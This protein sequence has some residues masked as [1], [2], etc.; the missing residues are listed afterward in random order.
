MKNIAFFILPLLLL[1]GCNT[2]KNVV[3]F[4]PPTE[5]EYELRDLDT[6]VITAPPYSETEELE[7]EEDYGLSIYNP[8]HKRVNDLLHTKLDLKFDWEN[9]HVLGK[10]TLTFEPYF[11]PTQTL[12]LDA[13]DFDI[14][15]V[16]LE[17]SKAELKYEYDNEKLIIDLGKLYKKGE[18][19]S[20]FIDYTA[21]PAETG[22]SAAI[23]SDQGL[24][25]INPK[26]EDGDKPQQI[27]TQ[28]ETEWNSRW[29]PTIDKPNERCTQEMLLTVQ[30]RFTTLSNGTLISSTPNN[31]GTRT[32]YWKMDQPHAPYLFMVAVGEYAVVKEN[33]KDV[34]L[35]YYVEPEY[36]SSAKDIFS[37][38]PEMLD[39]F[40]EKLGLKYPWPKY[41]QIVVRDYVSGAMENTT[42]VIYGEFVQK[43]SREI[44]D[45]HNEKIVAHELFHHWFGDYVT[46][47]SWAN[48]TMNEGFANY[49]EYLWLEH[50][51][52]KDEA[53][54]HML[55]E[56]SGYFSSARND[57]HPLIHFGHEDKE[58][59]FDA[60][61]YNKGGAVLHMLR[62]YVGD[63]AF[64]AALNLY[65]TDNAYSAVEVHDLRLAF[66]KVTG[67]DLNWFFNQWYLNEGH[68]IL[69]ITYAY[70]EATQLAIVSVE[71]LQDVNSSPAIFELPASVDI[72]HKN[73]TKERKSIRVNQRQQTFT[74][75]VEEKPNL[76]IF[77]AENVLLAQ[78]SDNRTEEEM[79]F[80]YRNARGF[81]DR[82]TAL[83]NLT[84]SDSDAAETVVKEA[85]ND[86]F[87][88]MR[89]LA[90]STLDI[91]NDKELIN[92]VKTLAVNDEDYNVRTTAI[93]KLIESGGESCKDLA[94][95]ILEKEQSYTVLSAALVLLREADST[96]VLE[97]AEKLEKEKN[98][99]I[100]SAVSIIYGENGDAS[101]LNFFED[102]LNEVDGFEALSFFS[103]YQ[104][105]L[106]KTD[107]KK[108]LESLTT[109]KSIALDDKQSP[110]RRIAI[111]KAMND[112]RNDYRQ[113]ANEE[114]ETTTKESLEA[115]VS[116]ISAMFDQIKSM[117]TNDQLKL[118][119][120]QF[121]LIDKA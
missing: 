5:E 65:L 21:K 72:Y 12:T 3:V 13:K 46:C 106:S 27:W 93:D 108:V 104:T 92:T 87:W 58:E 43:T 116:E 91:E 114:K 57:A 112:V 83:E 120:E 48:L 76:M 67:E 20:I 24:F 53:D 30:D 40:S 50:K 38:T 33:W 70:D 113:K 35:E 55:E 103:S 105:I 6:L 25:F 88:L 60:H 74:F 56:W 61:S 51:Y 94:K 8:S 90:L 45:E 28:G 118:L 121:Q 89:A 115:T 34:L 11:Y 4:D 85:L 95:E 26:G 96:A 97:Y 109:L 119:Y 9:E 47:E 110:W 2:S 41:S 73:G 101:H 10:A 14:H 69:D 23:T 54:Y 107:T 49:S 31:D 77:D 75:P 100:L 32:D 39:F 42:A 99:E 64:F 17:N 36:E 79:I 37:H 63:D 80:Q 29:F 15:S 52:G 18:K 59:M 16:S 81:L 84:E 68:P 86:D 62:N 1:F 102:N 82:Y 111:A 44:M 22:G 117:E 7:A 98:S 19:Y 78:R 71:Q 66:E